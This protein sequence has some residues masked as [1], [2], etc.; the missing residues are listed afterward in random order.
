MAERSDIKLGPGYPFI[1]FCD[2]YE[3]QI[4]EMLRGKDMTGKE[5]WKVTLVPTRELAD[6][7]N[8]SVDMLDEDLK[9]RR[10]FPID[11]LKQLNPDPANERWFCLLTF[12][13]QETEVSRMLG[14]YAEA[15]KLQ[16]LRTIINLL[17]SENAYMKERVDVANTNI[18][19][20]IKDYIMGPASEMTAQMFSQQM[21][22]PMSG[23]QM[24]S[25]VRTG[26]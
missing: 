1:F 7:Y 4:V 10:E 2:G 3:A 25:P 14:G 23:F 26:V 18:Q 12:D 5:V 22:S 16:E 20:Y 24:T 8:I 21:N 11:M 19:R 13:G 17:R 9:I 6:R 15:L